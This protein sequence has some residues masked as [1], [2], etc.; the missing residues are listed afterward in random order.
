MDAID[1]S[2]KVYKSCDELPIPQQ[3]TWIVNLSLLTIHFCTKV[4][5][6]KIEIVQLL[7]IVKGF[8][9]QSSKTTYK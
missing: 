5:P 7:N 2:W 1:F 4:H 6:C 3:L 8:M 9:V